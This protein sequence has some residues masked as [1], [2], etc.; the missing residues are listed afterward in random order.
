MILASAVLLVAPA[1]PKFKVS[2]SFFLSSVG[3]IF[4][5][6]LIV[7]PHLLFSFSNIVQCWSGAVFFSPRLIASRT[8]LTSASVNDFAINIFKSSIKLISAFLIVSSV[9]FLSPVTF[10]MTWFIYLNWASFHSVLYAFRSTIGKLS[11]QIPWLSPSLSCSVSSIVSGC[12]G[13][14]SSSLRF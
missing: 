5:S 1:C 7:S 6:S 10:S 14:C 13:S 3:N 2:S 11:H 4:W 12:W 9:L 8:R